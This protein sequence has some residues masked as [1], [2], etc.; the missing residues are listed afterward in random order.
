MYDCVLSGFALLNK[1]LNIKCCIANYYNYLHILIKQPIFSIFIQ[2]DSLQR[3]F[4]KRER[5]GKDLY[6]PDTP[7]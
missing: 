6:K 5:L 7:C 1:Q 2:S 3:E 4:K